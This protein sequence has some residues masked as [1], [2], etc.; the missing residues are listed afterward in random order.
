MDNVVIL[1]N[2]KDFEGFLIDDGYVDD[3]IFLIHDIK[4]E[5]YLESFIEKNNGTE[6][7]AQKLQIFVL[8]VIKIYS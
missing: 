1:D 5:E 7:K 2:G 4:G 8:N 3:L 6:T